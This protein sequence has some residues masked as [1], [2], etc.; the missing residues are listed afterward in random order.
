MSTKIV[1]TD[2]RRICW[3]E[4]DWCCLEGG[5]GYCNDG[6]WKYVSIIKAYAERVGMKAYPD[7]ES[8]TGVT[9]K[10]F[11]ASFHWGQEW[12]WPNTQKRTVP[13]R[14]PA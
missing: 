11:E 6:P 4:P 2:E 12:G 9:Y 3:P 7:P 1:Y 13:R 10:D 14:V 5:C 8:P